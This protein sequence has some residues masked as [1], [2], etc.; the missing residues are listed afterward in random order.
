MLV[1]RSLV[2][3]VSVTLTALVLAG[4]GTRMTKAPV[5]DRG[6]SS[7]SSSPSSVP[8][9][10]VTPIKPLPGA[11]NAGKPGYYTVKAGDTLIRIGLENGQGWKDIARWNNLDNANLIEVGQVLRVA[12]PS[13]TAATET[14]VVARPVASSAVVPAS[15]ASTPKPAAS[16]AVAVPAPIPAPTSAAAAASS[17]DDVPFIWP[18]SGTLL[19]GF[20]EA[21][22]KGYDI[23][24]K[25]GDPV[26]AAAD[27]RVVYAGAG[28]RGYGNLVILKHNNTFL[29]AYAHNQALLV[30]EDQTVRRG[31]KIAEMGS[32][33]ADRVKLHFEIRRQGKPVDPV[34]YLPAR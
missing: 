18:A 12:P 8:G 2:V 32:T 10:V 30:K 26:L 6:T 3:G 16:A 4:C 23:S 17:E 1:S 29:T 25:A 20:D 5:E 13:A 19:A 7:A 22:N 11:E 28:L 27:G 33:D 9:V 24:G 21:R 31:Q 15:A 14:G 34:R